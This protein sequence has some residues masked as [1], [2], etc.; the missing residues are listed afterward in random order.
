MIDQK[1]YNVLYHCE[2]CDRDGL[3]IGIPG[4]DVEVDEDEGICLKDDVV[5]FCY[6][7]AEKIE[8]NDVIIKQ[9]SGRIVF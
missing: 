8:T 5:I 6:N 9:I 1:L 7:C 4:S 2:N 3:A